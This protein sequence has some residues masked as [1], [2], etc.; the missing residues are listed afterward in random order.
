MEVQDYVDELTNFTRRQ[1]NGVRQSCEAGFLNTKTA[2]Q[3]L[4]YYGNC[5]HLTD[6]CNV[7]VRPE[8][9]DAREFY[10]DQDFRRE[11]WP[12]DPNRD[13]L[14]EQREM[15]RS[16]APDRLRQKQ[17]YE[18]FLANKNEHEPQSEDDILPN[19]ATAST[20]AS[21][22][23]MSPTVTNTD[24]S[25]AADPSVLPA[26]VQTPAKA[27]RFP[28]LRNSFSKVTSIFKRKSTSK[29]LESPP[30]TTPAPPA[31][32][33]DSSPSS[34]MSLEN[35]LQVID[36]SGGSDAVENREDL[37]RVVKKHIRNHDY[38]K[39]LKGYALDPAIEEFLNKDEMAKLLSV[40]ERVE[41]AISILHAD[42][43]SDSQSQRE[44]SS[45][46]DGLIS[47]E[48]QSPKTPTEANRSSE[49]SSRP[50]KAL[51]KTLSKT[52][53]NLQNVT[54]EATSRIT[55][56]FKKRNSSN[57][58]EEWQ[59]LDMSNLKDA[60]PTKRMRCFVKSCSDGIFFKAKAILDCRVEH[61]VSMSCELDLT[62]LWNKSTIG[63]SYHQFSKDAYG[64][65]NYSDFKVVPYFLSARVASDQ[66]RI[67]DED[68][69]MVIESVRPV[70]EDP[71]K[72]VFSKSSFTG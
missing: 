58:L 56:R 5:E 52:K 27:K 43:S 19:H 39:A 72:Y 34:T 66:L 57:S 48:P 54:A 45:G 65:K 68:R 23:Q 31:F 7:D 42:D 49:S 14:L 30:Q 50:I 71:A 36:S 59:E 25:P 38:A 2:F 16:T 9:V 55:K 29:D 11:V 6:A 12:N 51:K 47:E 60:G 26:Q 67:F 62:H 40:K 24:A 61:I 70:V 44:H 53:L 18:D 4:L 13:M 41:H 37:V 46:S 33:K 8:I 20:M 22:S 28:S 63:K 21:A 15:W 69:Q 10:L 3:K 64:A 32:L 35:V 17:A 1:V